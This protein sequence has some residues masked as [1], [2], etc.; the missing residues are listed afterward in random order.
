MTTPDTNKNKRPV[1]LVTGAGSGIGKACAT[2][3][4]SNGYD[5]ALVARTRKTLEETAAACSKLDPACQTLVLPADISEADM[6]DA[7]I[8]DITD[9]W[10][11]LDALLNIAGS[12]PLMPIDQITPQSWRSCIDSNLSGAV[13]LTAAAWPVFKRQKSGF[14]GNVSSM[15]SIDPFP[16][17]AMY[18][19]AKTGLN[20]FTHC[21]A[22]EGQA[23]NVRAVAVA[24]G[25]VE[26]PMLRQNFGQEIIGKDKTL[27]PDAIAQLLC[28]CLMKLRVF[29]SGETILLTSPV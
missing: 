7:I 10:G 14:V 24:P 9:H 15:A 17:F 20:M 5:I 13:L 22:Q 4:A 11:R 1:A 29:K 27:P 2:L 16:G 25:A 21:T 8:N 6:P 28:D 3:L 23:I 12:A 26:T 18:A 19:A